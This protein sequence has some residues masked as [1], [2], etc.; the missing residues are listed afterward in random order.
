M[1]VRWPWVTRVEERDVE[2]AS[3]TSVAK[4]SRCE[5]RGLDFADK[6]DEQT[7]VKSA[8]SKSPSLL[9]KSWKGFS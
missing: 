9:E 2:L 6:V 3:P 1:G 8:F 5:P 4:V 7:P